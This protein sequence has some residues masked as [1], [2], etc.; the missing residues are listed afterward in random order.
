MYSHIKQHIRMVQQIW[1]KKIRSKK[2]LGQKTHPWP[3]PFFLNAVVLY[4]I[5]D[6]SI[7]LVAVT[8]FALRTEFWTR[9]LFF[10]DL[11]RTRWTALDY[12]CKGPLDF[13]VPWP[14]HSSYSHVAKSATPMLSWIFRWLWLSK[15]MKRKEVY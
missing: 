5:S 2:R 1:R 9:E 13:H 12:F 6:S 3:P 7:Y 8:N 15:S 11:D 10:V 4:I 14:W